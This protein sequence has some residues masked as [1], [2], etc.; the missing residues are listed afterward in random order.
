MM[1]GIYLG[2]DFVSFA[3]AQRRMKPGKG[4]LR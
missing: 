1:S 3:E 2:N 4:A